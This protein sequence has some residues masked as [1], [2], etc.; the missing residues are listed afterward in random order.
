M[1][2]SALVHI[3]AA[4]IS[5]IPLVANAVP[6][7]ATAILNLPRSSGSDSALD[8]GT[9]SL[10]L[11][12]D[13]GLEVRGGSNAAASEGSSIK[14]EHHQTGTAPAAAGVSK[15]EQATEAEE[16][17]AVQ[18]TLE[19]LDKWMALDNRRLDHFG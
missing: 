16:Q 18:E 17:S 12:T 5:S 7:P 4:L 9:R 15:A 8:Y 11:N 2:A 1:R 19:V 3:V 13:T 6:V 10:L 14:L